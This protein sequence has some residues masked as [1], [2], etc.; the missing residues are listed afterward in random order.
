MIDDPETEAIEAGSASVEDSELAESQE[1][2]GKTLDRV[3][4]GEDRALSTV[5]REDGERFVRT[6]YGLLRMIHLHDLD[7]DAF[8]RPILELVEL[9][10]RMYELLGAINLV[11]VEEQ[12]YINDIRIR[13][14]E[15]AESGRMMGVELYRHRIGGLTLHKPLLTDDVKK[16]V[17]ILANDPD[18]STPRTVVVNALKDQG[19][20]GIELFGIYRFRVTGEAQQETSSGEE[21]SQ[22]EVEV[23]GVV[24]RGADLVE[25]GLNNLGANRMPNPLPLR[26]MVTEI[27]EGGVGAEGLWD[28]P[29][30]ENE[31]G[32][33]VVRVSRLCLLM[34]TGL[35]LSDEA[36]QDL[37]VAALFHD[38]GYAAREGAVAAKDGKEAVAGYAPPFE[39]HAA[40][41]V[42]LLLRQRG[43]HPAKVLRILATME[44]HD[45]F[46][47]PKGTP[48]LFGRIIRIAEDFDNLIRARGGA[49]T[50][51]DAIA[52]MVPHSGTRYDPDIFA[53]FVNMMGKYPPGT[54]MLL[55]DGCIAVSIGTCRSKETFDKPLV[56]IVRDTGGTVLEDDVTVDLAKTGSVRMVLN[57]RPERL[58]RHGDDEAVD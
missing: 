16:L 51:G 46:D 5:V 27:I 23:A 18:E 11:C 37:G 6:F 29:G 53:I 13:F 14:D 7:N 44:H 12:V 1:R 24:D 49:L 52:R 38:M 10:A 25:D 40:A 3:R 43:F 34:G 2:L 39:R 17:R 21:K 55:A 32:S 45:D 48:S 57:S 19:V 47:G 56:R 31:F 54:M 42:R 41:G 20:D 33:H 58:K 30:V 15:R 28:E 4:A 26:R 8:Q 22:T 50:S 36:L 35:G 9:S